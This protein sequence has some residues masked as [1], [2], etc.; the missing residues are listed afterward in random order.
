[1]F[2]NWHRRWRIRRHSRRLW[3]FVGQGEISMPSAPVL[4]PDFDRPTI[5]IGAAGGRVAGKL[6]IKINWL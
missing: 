5:L 2:G 1:M 4:S 6:A 3:Q